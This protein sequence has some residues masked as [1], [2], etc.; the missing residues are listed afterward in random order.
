[1]ICVS[2]CLITYQH[3]AFIRT[4]LE[5]VL[6]QVTQFEWEIVIGEDGSKDDTRKICAEFAERYPNQIRLLEPVGNLGMME[7]FMRT[8]Q[9]CRG[10]YIAFIEGDDYWTDSFKLQK[11]VDFL[12]VNPSFSACFHNVIIRTQRDGKD[13]ERIMHDHVLKSQFNTRDVLGPW[14]IA[15]TSF[16]FV[17]QPRL[18]I[19]DWVRHCKYGDLPIMLLLSLR[20][21]FGYLDDCMAVYRL[22]DQ[23]Y[24][25]LHKAMD[26]VVIMV[27]IYESF[28]IHTNYRF[29]DTVKES[30]HY[31]MSRHLPLKSASDV[32]NAGQS[33]SGFL[34]RLKR[35]VLRFI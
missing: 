34:Q 31:E 17:N 5:S 26:K 16:M 22:H 27:Y 21:D 7:N 14:F 6:A 32:E 33:S 20:G 25:T 23:G 4:A 29:A 13:E 35:Q 10:Q 24:T 1:M 18:E 15:S 28:N 11:Q 3:A 19:P 30:I 12:K 8:F 9:A 2:V